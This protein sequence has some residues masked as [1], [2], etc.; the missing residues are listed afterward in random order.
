MVT[1]DRKEELLEMIKERLG[2]YITDDLCSWGNWDDEDIS[3][4]EM[5]IIGELAYNIVID[6]SASQ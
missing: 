6:Y 5:D 1:K 2:S 3:P 4:D